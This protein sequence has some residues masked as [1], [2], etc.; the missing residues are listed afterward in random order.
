MKIR[1]WMLALAPF[2]L[3]GCADE[4]V[5]VTTTTVTREVTTTGPVATEP[6]GSD[7]YVTQAP[8]AVRVE[9]QTVAPGPGYTWTPGYWRWNGATYMWVSGSWSRPPR[10]AAVW[11]PGHWVHRPRGW[12]WVPG[13]WR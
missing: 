7:V 4:P 1:N 3:I 11:V 9:A 2:A 13:H 10:T 5:P 6:V 8:P 12:V